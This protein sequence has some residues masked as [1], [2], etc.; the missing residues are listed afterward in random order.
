MPKTI[1]CGI[2]REDNIFP[3]GSTLLNHIIFVGT[4]VPD[5]PFEHKCNF[6]KHK[7]IKFL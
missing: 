5:C 7:F 4:G 2:I 3:Y 6:Y 1:P